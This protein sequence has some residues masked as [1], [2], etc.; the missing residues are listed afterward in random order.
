MKTVIQAIRD[1][2]FGPPCELTYFFDDNKI[3]VSVNW[4]KEY[5]INHIAY[6]ESESKKHVVVRT[7]YPIKYI[8]KSLR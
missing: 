1:W 8:L 6:K 5:K 4:F 7:E 3:V 2:I